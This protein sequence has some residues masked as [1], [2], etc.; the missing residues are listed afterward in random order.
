[1]GAGSTACC[2]VSEARHQ[3]GL[4]QI[5]P[6]SYMVLF[7]PVP[8]RGHRNAP[9]TVHPAINRRAGAVV[10]AFAAPKGGFFEGEN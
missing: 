3:P 5:F 1:M 9:S 4:Y 2:Q 10:S 6:G 8:Q 7:L